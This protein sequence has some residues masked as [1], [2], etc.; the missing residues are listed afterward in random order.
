MFSAAIESKLYGLAVIAAVNSAVAAFYY[1]RI[2]RLMYLVPATHRE[3]VSQNPSLAF[4][5]ILLAS[6]TL[7][8]GL[9][10]APVISFVKGVLLV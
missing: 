4:A 2:V 1:F 6:A 10:P 9:V 8:I 7:A 3:E 5:I